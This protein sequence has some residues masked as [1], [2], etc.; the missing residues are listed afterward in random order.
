MNISILNGSLINHDTN[1][2]LEYEKGMI[3]Y[4]KIL[5]KNIK[6]QYD[7]I[8]IINKIIGPRINI[9]GVININVYE[10]K[11]LLCER[12]YIYKDKTK[13][14]F[15]MLFDDTYSDDKIYDI[16]KLTKWIEYGYTIITINFIEGV[17]ISDQIHVISFDILEAK[18]LYK[19]VKKYNSYN[20][21]DKEKFL[22]F[23]YGSDDQDLI[24]DDYVLSKTLMFLDY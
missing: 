7:K 20:K 21:L 19:L 10:F 18:N 17:S 5:L 6:S 22:K 9:K 11:K 13:I 24:L 1:N 16:K 3:D 12:K 8:F 4:L 2:N 23:S 14:C 15:V